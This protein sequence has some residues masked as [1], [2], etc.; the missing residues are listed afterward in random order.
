MRERL[1]ERAITFPIS[2]IRN[3]IWLAESYLV[4]GIIQRS[5]RS[6]TRNCA[7][8]AKL[9][10]PAE[11]PIP[12]KEF[13]GKGI[14]TPDIQLA[15]LALYQLSYAPAANADCRMEKAECK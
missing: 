13:G 12:A 5:R 6:M 10:S 2:A 11:R 9:A 1:S 8:G 7:F 4:A 3:G 14:R 15:K